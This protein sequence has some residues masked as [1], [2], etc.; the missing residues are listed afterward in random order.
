MSDLEF[1]RKIRCAAILG[2]FS[3]DVLLECLVLKGGN[4]LDIAYDTSARASIDLDFSMHCDLESPAVLLGRL[5]DGLTKSFREIGFEV[6]DVTLHE[7][8]PS[9]TDD[10]KDFWGGYRVE[11]KLATIANYHRFSHDKDML[12]RHAI[13]VGE[14]N[15]TKFRI[16]ISRHEYCEKKRSIDLEGLTIFVYSPEMIVCEK[17]RAICQQMQEYAPIV[18]RTRR[19]AARA[20]DFLDIHTICSNFAIDFRSADLQDTLRQMFHVKRVP[21]QLLSQIPAQREFHRPDFASVVATVKP[22]TSLKDF[23]FYFDF[24]IDQCDLLKALWEEDSPR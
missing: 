2:V 9:L 4:A 23:D 13:P 1:L 19:G 10:L 18:K 21:L 12:R 8:P 11:F 3:D 14:S 22:D 5:E 7:V 20:R 16:D 15:S 24:V 6:F 17:I